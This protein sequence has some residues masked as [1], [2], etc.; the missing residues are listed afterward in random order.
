MDRAASFD[1]EIVGSPELF[2]HLF[3]SDQG[4]APAAASL[5]PAEL[6]GLHLL[7]CLREAVDVE[8]FKRIYP[9]AVSPNLYASYNE[10]FK[11]LFQE[12]KSKLIQRGLLLFGTLTGHVSQG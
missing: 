4:V 6:A 8:F 1:P 11:G 7:N 12:V 10:R 2:Q 3:L 5:T 9:A